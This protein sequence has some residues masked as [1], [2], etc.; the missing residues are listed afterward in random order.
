MPRLE[1]VERDLRNHPGVERLLRNGKW[2]EAAEAAVDFFLRGHPSPKPSW[3]GSE[4]WRDVAD[5]F[6]QLV[7]IPDPQWRTVQNN[8][9]NGTLKTGNLRPHLGDLVE[10]RGENRPRYVT[11]VMGG[12]EN[13]HVA[14]KGQTEVPRGEVAYRIVASRVLIADADL[15]PGADAI[16]AVR[17]QA[18]AGTL[19]AEAPATPATEDRVAGLIGWMK[20]H[21]LLSWVIVAGIV[22][23]A[24][25]SFTE[26][27]DKLI[28][29]YRKHFGG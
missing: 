9:D 10:I 22:V 26:A 14:F 17:G 18:D 2:R 8:L 3:Y 13:C 28:S 1:H 21:P 11:Y 5:V 6:G 27:V 15:E 29:I 4:T 19:T 25:A 24:A 12:N 23:I 16:P 7:A 20:S